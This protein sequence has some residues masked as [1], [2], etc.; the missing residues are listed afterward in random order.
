M[1]DPTLS[2]AADAAKP[3]T[4]ALRVDELFNIIAAGPSDKPAEVAALRAGVLAQF[5]MRQAS[6]GRTGF[7]VPTLIAFCG[8]LLLI[9]TVLVTAR[10]WSPG[11]TKSTTLAR[12]SATFASPRSARPTRP[13]GFAPPGGSAQHPRGRRRSNPLATGG[14]GLP[15]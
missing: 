3:A 5:L 11:P 12:S 2:F 7:P 9:G 1:A 10:R 6:P 4:P 13:G 15:R 8:G 14:R